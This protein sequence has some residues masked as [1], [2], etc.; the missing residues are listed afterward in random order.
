VDAFV[1]GLR[2]E[3]SA[4][5]IQLSF[6]VNDAPFRIQ[7]P[8]VGPQLVG[9]FAPVG[10]TLEDREGRPISVNTDL[11]GQR[12]DRRWPGPLATLQRGENRLS[13][14]K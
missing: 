3:N 14:Q 2:R 6:R 12:S 7:V 11:L 5:G 9:V 13:W 4:A 8:V 10:Q 1:V